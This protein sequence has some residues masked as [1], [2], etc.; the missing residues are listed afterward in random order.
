ME[1]ILQWRNNQS[2]IKFILRHNF[3]YENSISK[4]NLKKIKKLTKYLGTNFASEQESISNY[5]QIN[6]KL[7][8][9]SNPC[10]KIYSQSKSDTYFAMECNPSPNVEMDLQR[11]W[12]TLLFSLKILS[13]I[14]P[15]IVVQ[16]VL[17]ILDSRLT[18][19][20]NQTHQVS[21]TT[22]QRIMYRY[23]LCT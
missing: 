9:D 2:Q 23:Y 4:R 8:M 7:D 5:F 11:I 3:F 10:Q 16:I 20:F 22:A 18:I 13:Q 12:D 17:D 21:N 14:S 15:F 1:R 6:T 19:T